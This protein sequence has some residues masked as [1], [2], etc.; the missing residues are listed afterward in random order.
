[1][2]AQGTWAL[3]GKRRTGGGNGG[4]ARRA[5]AVAWENR[6]LECEGKG[7]RMLEEGEL[8][9]VDPVGEFGWFAIGVV[10]EGEL[11][12]DAFYAVL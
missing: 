3:R 5:A 11:G 4:I 2:L 12:A 6:G 1:M 9:A 7:G 8:T 10:L